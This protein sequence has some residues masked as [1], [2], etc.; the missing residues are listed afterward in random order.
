MVQVDETTRVRVTVH[1]SKDTSAAEL[2]GLLLSQV[3]VVVG[4]KHTICE[5]LTGS[6]TEQVPGESGAV[7]VDVV[8]S[9]SF[10]GRHLLS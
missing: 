8:E 6:D 3:I 9:G 4:V 2:E 5:G 7:G 10:L 1:G